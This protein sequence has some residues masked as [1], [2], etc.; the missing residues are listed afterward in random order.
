MEHCMRIKELYPDL[1][2]GYDLVGQEEPD[3]T[4]HDLAPMM[5][6]FK[7]QCVLRDLNFPFF[8]KQEN[9]WYW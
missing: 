4:L 7:E 8:F 9:A 5:L 2:S 6:W 1:I 3:R